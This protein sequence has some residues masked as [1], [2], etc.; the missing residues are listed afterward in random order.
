VFWKP[1]YN[2][3]EPLFT[4]WVANARHVRNVPGR[5]TDV[6]DA[7]W[8][9]DLLRHGLVQPSFIPPLPQRDLRA[10]TRQR[11]ILGQERAAVVNR[12]HKVLEWA[13]LK[14]TSVVTDVTGVSARAILE[15]LLAGEEDPALLAEL[16]RGSLRSKREQLAAALAGRVREHHRFLLASHLTHLD[17]LDEQIA[18]F[19]AQISAGLAAPESE[20]APP[21]AADGAATDAPA[22]ASA[23]EP[24]PA[25]S[26]E[27]VPPPG[28]AAALAVLDAIPGIGSTV[29]EVLVAEVGTDMSRFAS[30]RHLV[31]WAKLAPGNN[32]SAGKRYS[33]KTGQGSRWLRSALVQAA[34]AAVRQSENYFAA[35]YRRLVV[36]L[37][38]KRAIIAVA[39]RILIA[40]YHVLSTGEPYHER[41]AAY[42][43]ER[44]REQTVKRLRR[45]LEKLG[46]QVSLELV[47]T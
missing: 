36:R 9:A 11:A 1:V 31:S 3:L 30:D 27:S 24:V 43:D 41:G 23:R 37:G 25:S 35:V 14:L 44:Q 5:K 34:W 6:G 29:A 16:A 4:V 15:A 47:A 32:I 17:F 19:N 20:P 21:P 13:N 12:L 45:R 40:V 33:A 28:G 46:Y 38:P 22:P 26:G 7:E 10:L 18:T 2:I 42:H 39:R 8:L